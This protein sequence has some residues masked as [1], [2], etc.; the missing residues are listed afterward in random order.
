MKISRLITNY[1]LFA[2]AIFGMPTLAIAQILPISS[3]AELPVNPSVNT[4][5]VFDIDQVLIMT[6][7]HFIHPHAE[8][9]FL[10]KRQ[11]AL[12][13][14]TN[15]QELKD[16][17]ETL[18][19][20]L[21]MPKRIL[22]E[23]ESP[24]ILRNLRKSAKTIAL[25]SM[26]SGKFGLI[27]SIADWRVNHLKTLD[28]HFNEAFVKHERFVLRELEKPGKTL[29]LYH[30]GIL[31]SSGYTKGEVLVAF[32]KKMNHYPSKVIFVD[33]LIENLNSV[34]EALEAL[35]IPFEG[36]H[37]LGAHRYFQEIDEE[38]LDYQFQHLIQRKE[39]LSDK[40]VR[41]RLKK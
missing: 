16:M 10:E 25:T 38:L 34:E 36:Y 20:S 27:P 12:E 31:F 5:V 17:E 32:F 39:W 26:P 6:E 37:Y 11:K 28:I 1:L 8:H 40:E 14:A 19:L 22:V 35:G 41:K 23:N 18:S 4:L 24:A 3:L 7:D 15:E 30:S 9:I 2:I 29:P 13:S 33:D 21:L